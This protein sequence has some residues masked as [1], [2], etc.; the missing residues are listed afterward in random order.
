M[1][2]ALHR[3]L[4]NH[5][6]EQYQEEKVLDIVFPGGFVELSTSVRTTFAPS[7]DAIM[8]CVACKIKTFCT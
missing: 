4:F 2:L 3:E 7:F 1:Q 8:A 6:L 5:L